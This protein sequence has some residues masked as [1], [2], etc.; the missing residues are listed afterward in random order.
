MYIVHS[1]EI[2]VKAMSVNLFITGRS[3]YGNL[4]KLLPGLDIRYVDLNL[5]DILKAL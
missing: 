4:T 2:A 5:D 3:C 1:L